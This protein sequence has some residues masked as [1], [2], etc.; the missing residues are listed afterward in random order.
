MSEEI[1]E[2]LEE[3]I[4]QNVEKNGNQA[5]FVFHT[6]LTL[7]KLLEEKKVLNYEE[8]I[9]ALKTSLKNNLEENN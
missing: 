3:L 5:D 6:V 2:G 9:V 1:F 7:V 4:K 8:Y